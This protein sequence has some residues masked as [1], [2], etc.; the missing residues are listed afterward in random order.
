M[1]TFLGISLSAAVIAIA[2][3]FGAESA[4]VV[5]SARAQWPKALQRARMS[6][7][8]ERLGLTAEQKAQLK[9]IRAQTA[10]AVQ[11]IRANAALT[12][13]QKRAQA[14]TAWKTS[15]EQMRALL[16][17]DQQAKLAQIKSHPW[18]LNALAVSRVRMGLLANQLGLT[19]DQRAKIRDIHTKT[20]TVVNPI[21]ADASLTPEAK[22]AKV[23]ELVEAS[24]T[25]IHGVLTPEQE[26]KL[27]R[28][29]RRLLAPLGPLG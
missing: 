17:P 13:D 19:S 20:V 29:R 25:E 26:A 24:R 16:T 5:P 10:E 4:G 22:R 28:I 27:Q 8:A 9:T 14:V 11:A 7:V 18:R 6:I 15:R 1:K 3:C 21:R 12:A 23:R 2:A